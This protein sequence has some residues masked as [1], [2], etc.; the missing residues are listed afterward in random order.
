[1]L[2]TT[3]PS[4]AIIAAALRPGRIAPFESLEGVPEGD[5]ADAVVP[6]SWIALD[7]KAAKL[8][9]P[10]STAFTLKTIPVPQWPA[11]R[12]Y[13]QIGWV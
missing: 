2:P 12:Q 1:M 8:L 7:W 10:D 11:W 13:A 3:A 9:G 5:D 4:S 6:L